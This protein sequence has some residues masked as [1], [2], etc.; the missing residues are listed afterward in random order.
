[1]NYYYELNKLI[2]FYEGIKAFQK[3]AEKFL[4]K[5]NDDN[6][7]N[8]E[9]RSNLLKSYYINGDFEAIKNHIDNFKKTYDIYNKINEFKSVFKNNIAVNNTNNTEDAKD[10]AG[11]VNINYIKNINSVNRIDNI[12]IDYNINEFIN[13]ITSEYYNIIIM[14]YE[15]LTSIDKN[16]V[17]EIILTYVEIFRHIDA[18]TDKNYYKFNYTSFLFDLCKYLYEFKEYE[19]LAFFYNLMNFSKKISDEFNLN[20]FTLHSL[21]K[22]KKNKDK[23]LNAKNENKKSTNKNEDGNKNENEF[24]CQYKNKNENGVIS[25]TFEEF[26]EID[27]ANYSDNSNVEEN[28]AYNYMNSRFFDILNLWEI[29]TNNYYTKDEIFFMSA[30]FIANEY[31]PALINISNYNDYDY[32]CDIN[33]KYQNNIKSNNR[34]NL[35]L[36][37]NSKGNG[38]FINRNLIYYNDNYFDGNENIYKNND[39]SNIIKINYSNALKLFKKAIELNSCNPNYYYEYAECLR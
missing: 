29:R 2:R 15:Y 39:I 26:D 17:N 25:S 20:K 24:K 23:N 10:I 34:L 36:N 27:N 1:M 3:N 12:N 7:K 9:L 33:S 35:N 37:N 32:I 19:K 22:D 18:I 30:L 13:S 38:N 4:T 6:D 21:N 31:I 5:N 11:T 28:K 8:I 14:S 16:Y